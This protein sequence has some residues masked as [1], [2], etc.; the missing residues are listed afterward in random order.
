MVRVRGGISRVL[1]ALVALA[2]GACSQPLTPS[3]PPA[4][5]VPPARFADLQPMV[6][7]FIL[8]IALDGN[9]SAFPPL[10]QVRSYRATLEDRGWHYL[11]VSVLGGGF[12]EPVQIGDL[13]TGEL[14][15]R[16]PTEPQLR[17]NQFEG[18]V[19][20]R[21]PLGDAGTLSLSG[22]GPALRTPSGFLAT[23][24]GTAFLTRDG[25]VSA[26]C[27]GEHRFVFDSIVGNVR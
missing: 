7:R 24:T 1:I 21:E 4:G 18:D 3:A 17:W 25:R 6:G 16:I 12:A 19:D 8:T 5:T 10:A 14:S 11:V 22:S 27:V 2:L 9:C 15:L 26:R 13:M 23:V 20:G